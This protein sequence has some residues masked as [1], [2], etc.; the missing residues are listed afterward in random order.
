MLKCFNDHF[1]EKTAPI[2][3]KSIMFFLAELIGDANE[4]TSKYNRKDVRY[5]FE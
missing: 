1:S 2:S 3:N 4:Q 5:K